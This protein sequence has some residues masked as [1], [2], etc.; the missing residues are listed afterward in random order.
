MSPAKVSKVN[1]RL[2]IRIVLRTKQSAAIS[3]VN[4]L[5]YPFCTLSFPNS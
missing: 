3:Q 2:G 1:T 4:S 5:I